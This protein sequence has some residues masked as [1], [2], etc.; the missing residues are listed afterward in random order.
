M[1]WHINCLKLNLIWTS[2]TNWIY[3]LLFVQRWAEN[4]SW[5]VNEIGMS[6]AEM[7]AILEKG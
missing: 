7:L 4:K 3:E 5:Q 6:D 1:L 2:N